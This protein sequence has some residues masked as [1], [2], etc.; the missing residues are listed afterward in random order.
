MAQAQEWEL[1]NGPVTLPDPLSL[2]FR[3]RTTGQV[4]SMTLTHPHIIGAGSG[5]A[6]FA[7]EEDNVK[8]VLLKVSWPT[9]SKTVQRECSTLQ[10][11]EDAG[12][13]AAERCLAALTYPDPTPPTPTKATTRPPTTDPPPPRSM[14][15]VTPYM[16]DAV[17]SIDEVPTEQARLVAVDQVARTLVQMLAANIITIDV[18]P[19]ISKTTGRTIF[20]DMT[21]AQV[22]SSSSSSSTSTSSY[23]SFLDQTLIASFISEM[24]TLIPE[25]YWKVAQTS[26]QDE[27][28]RLEVAEEE[29]R[30]TPPSA[31][32]IRARVAQLLHEQTPFSF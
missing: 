14:I 28:N 30:A 5:G 20:I 16:A 15:I 18:Q 26:I 21:E 19:L 2:S 31:G 9:T 7:F 22:L 4:Q 25:A 13:H 12:V 11:L 27:L 8:N 23:Y 10:L 32:P 17:A 3:D 29:P 1:I 6:V 24:V